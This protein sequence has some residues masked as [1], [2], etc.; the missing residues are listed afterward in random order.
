M[1]NEFVRKS[2]TSEEIQSI[3]VEH[4]RKYLDPIWIELGKILESLSARISDLET[5]NNAMINE[6][7]A[8]KDQNKGML[9]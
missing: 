6:M 4:T 3:V 7:K 8:W 9:Q 5:A 1:P 2:F